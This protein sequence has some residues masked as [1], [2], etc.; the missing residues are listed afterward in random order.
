MLERPTALCF[1]VN[2]G[3]CSAVQGVYFA[4]L[5]PAL[6]FILDTD[7]CPENNCL[8][9]V[10]SHARCLFGAVRL[11]NRLSEAAFA[12]PAHILNSLRSDSKMWKPRLG[13]A[14]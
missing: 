7:S 14:F 6:E 3:Y 1:S 9:N 2:E 5:K 12:D 11:K 4:Y 13:K 8:S 10:A